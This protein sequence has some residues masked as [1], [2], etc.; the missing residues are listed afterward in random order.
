MRIDRPVSAASLPSTIL[1][2]VGEVD[3]KDFPVPSL[4]PLWKQSGFGQQWAYPISEM[5][6]DLFIPQ[7][8]P[9][10]RGWLK[11]ITDPEW[12]LIVSQTDPAELYRYPQDGTESRNLVDSS[13]GKAV[14]SIE[15][16]QLWNQVSP[17]HKKA[18]VAD[19]S[20]ESKI[21]R[22]SP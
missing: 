2:E 13:Q 1:E 11:S 20:K 19:P 17:E 9:G 21:A 5:A 7:R 8:Y 6:Q 16:T 12:H 22:F 10:Y 15:E 3:Q 4:T 18:E 14:L